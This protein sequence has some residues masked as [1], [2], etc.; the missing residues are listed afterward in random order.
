ML[1]CFLSGRGDVYTNGQSPVG[2]HLHEWKTLQKCALEMPFSCRA[3]DGELLF[4]GT[5]AWQEQT[6]KS[7]AQER[8]AA[9]KGSLESFELCSEASPLSLPG[10]QGLTE[11]RKFPARG[12]WLN[13]LWYLSYFVS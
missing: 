10:P 12:G 6:G 5:W 11:P 13:K 9:Q 7:Q 1:P 4:V 8:G 3:V 2:E